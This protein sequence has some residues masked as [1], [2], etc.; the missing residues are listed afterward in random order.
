MIQL[1]S[2]GHLIQ[3]FILQLL[4][5]GSRK[6]RII[7]SGVFI[8]IITTGYLLPEQPVI[9][10]QGATT[11][12][13]HPKTFWFEPW[14]SSRVHKGM[15]IFAKTGTPIVA[16]TNMLILR[17]GTLGKGGKIILALGP[18]WTLHYFAHLDGFEPK[19][20]F[21]AKRG[22]II[23]YVG[24]TGNAKGKPPHLHYA[25]YNIIP[26]PWKID[27]ATLGYQKMFYKDPTAYLT[28]STD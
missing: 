16:S 2:G 1:I 17:R 5:R 4:T 24:D 3:R 22:E 19:A 11:Q 21:F 9:P 27:S 8:A 18:K 14:G 23:G 28:Q 13:W 7:I 15:D 6:R 20:G 10:V 12:D 25:L 26:Q